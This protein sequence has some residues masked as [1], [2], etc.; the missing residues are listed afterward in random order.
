[1]AAAITAGVFLNQ[2]FDRA[3]QL[4]QQFE[5]A[6]LRLEIEGGIQ[7]RQTIQAAQAAYAESL[8][9]TMDRIDQTA[10]NS[11]DQ[12]K[13]LVQ[14]AESGQTDIINNLSSRAQQIA[15]TLPGSNN[16]PQLIATFPR[17]VNVKGLD[18]TFRCLG[19]FFHAANPGYGATLT[20]KGQTFNPHA[21][22]TQTLEFRVPSHTIFPSNMLNS[23]TKIT[24]E[25]GAL[26]L[27]FPGGL[28]GGG[29][30]ATFNMTVG[31]LPI[32]PGKITLHWTTKHTEKI[33][34]LFKSNLLELC[35]RSCCGNN[36]QEKLF[37]QS[38][39][40]GW[41][42]E[43]GSSK[44]EMTDDSGGRKEDPSFERDEAQIVVYRAKTIHNKHD[45]LNGKEAGWMKFHILF[46]EWQEKAVEDQH[47]EDI[48]LKWNDSKFFNHPLG[49]WKV[50]YD[51]FDGTHKE[52]AGSD[53]LS[54][55]YV[56]IENQG[57]G[58]VIKAIDPKL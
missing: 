28:F 38:P 53:L 48:S 44:I 42:V 56:Q 16:R 19:N 9:L 2:L 10:R 36:D 24:F 37:T 1:M 46:T 40:E 20:I 15:N 51:A 23:A 58:F 34:Q 4:V 18:I 17:Y 32:S 54:S 21:N 33:T 45:F 26:K 30:I 25:E 43:I 22:S 3:Q 5:N 39:H 8:N 11:F 31:A 52:F 14:L 50:T 6:G 41:K 12:M 29:G 47:S 57:N 7:L 13:T 35:S 27:P 55:P 49:T